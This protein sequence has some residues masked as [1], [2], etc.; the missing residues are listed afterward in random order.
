[1]IWLKTM[2]STSAGHL[3][4]AAKGDPVLATI[5]VILFYLLFTAF[6]TTVERAAFG[7]SF[8]HLLDPIFAG[9]FIAYAAYAVYACAVYNTAVLASKS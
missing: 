4:S 5:V 6:E 2:I 1:M 9:F 8:P 3:A 7:K